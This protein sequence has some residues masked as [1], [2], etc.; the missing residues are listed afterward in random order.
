MS[1]VYPEDLRIGSYV[2]VKGEVVIAHD[3]KT[4]PVTNAISGNILF[5]NV[6][7]STSENSEATIVFDD[8]GTMIH[9]D[10]DSDLYNSIQYLK[11]L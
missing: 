4:M 5:N 7:I 6:K 2:S 11:K 9:L 3:D 10:P 1:I 8:R